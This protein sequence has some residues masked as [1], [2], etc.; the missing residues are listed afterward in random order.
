MQDTKEFKAELVR[1]NL[2]DSTVDNYTRAVRDLYLFHTEEV[3]GKTSPGDLTEIDMRGY[4]SHLLNIKKQSSSTINSKLAGLI[5]YCDF[6][7]AW[8]IL[9]S[10]PAKTID[11]V[12]QQNNQVAPKTLA[13]TICMGYGEHFIRSPV[14]RGIF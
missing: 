1:Q 11:R 3:G 7:I 8:G 14:T 5:K 9:N 10:N 2:S 12:K 13:K 4:K 6:L